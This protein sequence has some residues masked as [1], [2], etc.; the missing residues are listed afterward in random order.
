MTLSP[1]I[2]ILVPGFPTD[3]SDLSCLPPIQNYVEA[4]GRRLP[5]G[6]V[7]VVAFQYPFDRRSY[8]WRGVRVHSMGGENASI[9]KPRIWMNAMRTCGRLMG[10][11]R[12]GVIHSFWLG[13]CA[14]VGNLLA[15]RYEWTHL[16]S[17][18]GQEV[19]KQTIYST[20]LRYGTF[21]LTAG[22]ARAAAAARAR[23]RR[24]VD[25]VIPLG[26]DVDRVTSLSRRYPNDGRS[27]DILAVGSL[28]PLKR[29]ED[30]IETAARLLDRYP[31][32]RVEI[33]GEGPQR[34]RL[35][36][37][38]N[39]KGVEGHV[40]LQGQLPREEVLHRMQK[41]KLL[42]HTS[43]YESQGYVFLEALATGMFVVCRDVGFRPESSS[44]ALATSVDEMV[45]AV[46][47]YLDYPRA[48]EP[49]PVPTADE[50]VDAF[51]NFYRI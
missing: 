17:I 8:R 35:Q 2:L 10:E 1:P 40:T 45:E 14:L 26:L 46:R 7:D 33:I 32:L 15:R 29:M 4:L 49:T 24:D 5:Q 22:S 21:S 34:A 37:L 39:A 11:R 41:S 43:E 31:G 9:A 20:L 51:L 47:W 6:G 44:V 3:E 13:E 19:R 48:P 27:I 50:T 42:L 12:Q 16:V 28:T 36:L 23:L 25:A 38:I 18:G 30:V